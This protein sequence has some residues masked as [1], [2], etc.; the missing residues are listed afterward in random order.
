MKN[1]TATLMSEYQICKRRMWLH[2]HQVNM[3]QTSDTV[4]E[5]K[6]I[7]ETTY[8]Q[9]AQRYTEV[10]LAY[11][12]PNGM[13]ALAKI[14]FFDAKQKVVHEV[15]KSNKLEHAHIAQVKFY[16]YLLEKN[17]VSGCRGILEYPKL[18]Q[19]LAIEPLTAVDIVEIEASMA[20]IQLVLGQARCPELIKKTYCKTCSYHDFCFIG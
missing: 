2:A 9:R 20:D 16:L 18:R 11:D 10:E 1:I 7:G 19:T 5:G 8:L 6:L 17:G 13:Q 15:K 3:E 4:S 14:D 12:F